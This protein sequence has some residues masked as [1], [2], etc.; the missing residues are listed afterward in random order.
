MEVLLGIMFGS[1]FL[2]VVGVSLWIR[3]VGTGTKDENLELLV[4]GVLLFLIFGLA[5]VVFG[6]AWG[7]TYLNSYNKIQQLSAFQNETMSA[8]QYA[9][10]R[11]ENVEID[12]GRTRDGSFTDFSYQQQGQAVSERTKE[13]RNMVAWYN[14]E[15][16]KL[17]GRNRI[18]VIGAM[19]RDVPEDLR[20]IK[21]ESLP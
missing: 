10:D 21:L 14:R 1:L 6:I 17:Q 9:I 13:L 15:F 7:T 3:G 19:Y 18:P 12:A 2:T 20:P 16:Y 4:P 8:Y 11:T 5:T